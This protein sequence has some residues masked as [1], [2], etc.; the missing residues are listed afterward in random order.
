MRPTWLHNEFKTILV[1]ARLHI[2]K[3][4]EKQNKQQKHEHKIAQQLW[5]GLAPARK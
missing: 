2:K 4:K 3:R 5:E 1:H